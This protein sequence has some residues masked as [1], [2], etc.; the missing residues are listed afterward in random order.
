MR[1]PKILDRVGG[2][3]MMSFGASFFYG[4]RLMANDK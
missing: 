1:K 2:K 3:K 4:K